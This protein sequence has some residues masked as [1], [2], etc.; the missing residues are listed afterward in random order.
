MNVIRIFLM[1]GLLFS[2][3]SWAISL[4]D[5]KAQG[6]IGE[7]PNGYIGAVKGNTRAAGLI[8]EINAKREEAYQRIATKRGISIE[9]VAKLAGKKLIDKASPNEYIRLPNGEWV[10]KKQAR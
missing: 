5:A 6:M 2:L 8:K 1:L 7:Q 10:L 9:Q 3:P 4:E